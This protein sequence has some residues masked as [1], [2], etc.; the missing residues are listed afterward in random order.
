MFITLW[1]YNSLI[2]QMI[3]GYF[4][5]TYMSLKITEASLKLLTDSYKWHIMLYQW[6]IT[7]VMGSTSDFFGVVTVVMGSTSD[8]VGV[9]TVV[10]GTTSD[11][12]G[13]CW[14]SF[15]CCVFCLVYLSS[16]SCAPCCLRLWN[17]HSWLPFPFFLTFI[18]ETV[19][20]W[21]STT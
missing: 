4:I 2:Q 16:M 5:R 1:L 15:L 21:D 19:H 12:F 9:V 17:D 3:L 20:R 14:F 18:Y 7:V 10:M 8:I 13:Y 6:H 11:I